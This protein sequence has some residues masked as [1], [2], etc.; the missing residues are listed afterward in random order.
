MERYSRLFLHY[1]HG[2]TRRHLKVFCFVFGARLTNITRC[3]RQLTPDVALRWPMN[4]CATG[5]AARAH[6]TSL[7]GSTAAGRAP[8]ARRGNA[9]IAARQRRARN[10][11]IGALAQPPLAVAPHG[12]SA[13]LAQPA[14]ALRRFRA[15]RAAASARCSRMS[16]VSCRCTTSPALA[17]LAQALGSRRSTLPPCCTEASHGNSKANVIPAPIRGKSGPA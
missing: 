16:I 4:S 6:R 11:T 15:A 10:A 9:A 7:D 1:V 5:R 14:A 3:L 17:D 12:A 8:R 13:R 2:L